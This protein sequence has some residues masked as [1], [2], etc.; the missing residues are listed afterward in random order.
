M[1]AV[2]KV[3]V[4]GAVVPGVVAGADVTTLVTGVTVVVMIAGVVVSWVVND[5]VVVEGLIVINVGAAGAASV[6]LVTIAAEPVAADTMVGVV[7]VTNVS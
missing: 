1:E 7:G 4:A 3:L 6:V 5:A 2:L